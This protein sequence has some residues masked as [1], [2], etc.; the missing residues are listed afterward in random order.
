MGKIKFWSFRNENGNAQLHIYGPIDSMDWWGDEITPNTF[1][2]ELDALGDVSELSVYIN[3]DGG[4]VFAGQ[5]IHTMLKRHKAFINIYI[6]GLAASIASVIAMAGDKVYMPRNSMMMVHNPWTIAMGNSSDFRKMADDLDS[7]RESL[8][9][10]YQEK[11]GMER[12][13]IIAL[14]D[15]ETWLTADEAVN[16]GFADEVEQQK[17]I[18]ASLQS[19]T[20]KINGQEMD[21]KKFKHAPK[22]IVTSNQTTDSPDERLQKSL[23][24][25]EKIHSHSERKYKQ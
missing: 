15:A 10:A 17:E 25:R 21:L 22:M 12:D 3:S 8:I 1:K 5:T 11:S 19:G 14:L 16:L 9:A 23:F 13:A 2:S 18:A 24:L 20:L 6:D 7:I 4:D